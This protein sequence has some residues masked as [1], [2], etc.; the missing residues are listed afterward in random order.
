MISAQA[1]H[2][3]RVAVVE[4]MVGGERGGGEGIRLGDVL[5]GL[6][7]CDVLEDNFQFGEIA[8][9]PNQLGVDEDRLAVEQVDVRVGHLA[10][11]Q[12]RQA[13]TLHRLHFYVDDV[14]AM[15][16]RAVAA[17][18]T[19]EFA[20]RDARWGERYF[21]LRDPDGHELSFARPIV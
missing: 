17:G 3:E 21:H 5:G 4:Q 18:F 1:T 20:P 14:D 12:Q 10:V 11:H 8:P 7:G 6:L 15:Y 2:E 9:Q 16:A 19:P 13:R